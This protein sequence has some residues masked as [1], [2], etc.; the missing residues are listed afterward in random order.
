MLYS[1]KAT[2]QVGGTQ[3]GDIDAPNIDLA[4]SS[5]QRRGLTIVYINPVQEGESFFSKLSIFTRIPA[6]DVVILSRQLATLFEAKVAV[7]TI[8]KLLSSES[9]NAVLREKLS[10]V[11][12]DIQSG[13]T[14]SAALGKH[15]AL[16]SSFYVSMVRAGEESGKLAETFTYLADYLER[17]YEITSKVR[18]A[19]IYPAFVIFS[20]VVV[21]VLMMVV[22]IPKLSGILTETGQELPFYTRVI[23]ASSSFLVNYGIFIFIL[24]LVLAFAVWRYSQTSSG[25]FAMSYF[26]LNIPY[27]GS[28]YRKLYLSRISDNMDTMLSS[29]ISMLRAIEISS[30]VVDNAV[31]EKIL[32]ESMEAVKSGASLSDAFSRHEEMPPIVVQMA[33]IGE[34][35]GKLGFVLKTISRFYKREV[36]SAIDNIVSLIEP[37]MIVTLGIGVGFLLV[38]VLGPIYNITGSI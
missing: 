32:A 21:M 20:F 23:L 4:I 16:F 34:E 24:L 1:Y 29:G 18:N 9:E 14:I 27:V 7:L 6:R 10:T 30:Q 28:L 26:K 35:T 38:G 11:V 25:R 2:T 19:L 8:F 22:V 15:P 5:L 31:Y 36:D 13:V 37:V 12:D 17:S 33:R 3:E